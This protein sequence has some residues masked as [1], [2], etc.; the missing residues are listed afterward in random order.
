MLR[1]YAMTH[2]WVSELGLPITALFLL[3]AG[4]TDG[5]KETIQPEP[6]SGGQ[7]ERDAAVDQTS[8]RDAAQPDG[9]VSFECKRAAG[10][11][12]PKMVAVPAPNGST[13]CI[14]TTEVTQG[15]YAEFLEAKGGSMIDN[16][17]DMSGQPAGCELNA[18]YVSARPDD[19][20][21]NCRWTHEAFD[22]M[23]T[24]PDFPVGCVDWCDAYMYCAWAG[25]RLCGAM[26]GGPI[27]WEQQSNANVSEWYNACSQGGTLPYPY[28]DAYDEEKCARESV[29]LADEVGQRPECHG[30]EP[31]FDQLFDMS[32][33][34]AEWTNACEV[35]EGSKYEYCQYR[36]KFYLPPE[37]AGYSCDA[38]ETGSRLTKYPG[39]GFRCCLD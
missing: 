23:G 35:A 10:L 6:G 25:K 4:C 34:I 24:H 33:N 3:V 7:T 38:T 31:P 9:A 36:G 21:P 17:D 39:L 16:P 19:E 2:E 28:G 20:P 8:P 22:P 29:A 32:G 11:K 18:R 27:A 37:P 12:G 30:T 14:D 1:S 26:G 13:Y 5:A 15:Q